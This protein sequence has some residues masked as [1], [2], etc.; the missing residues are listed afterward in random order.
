MH[1]RTLLRSG[2][3]AALAGLAGCGAIL[4]ESEAALDAIEGAADS[5]VAAH[6][7]LGSQYD[8]FGRLDETVEFDDDAVR[9]ELSTAREDLD[10]AEESARLDETGVEIENLRAVADYLEAL[11]DAGAGLATG[12]NAT[13]DA[14]SAYGDGEYDAAVSDLGTAA[15]TIDGVSERISNAETARDRIDAGSLESVSVEDLDDE[16]EYL[17][18]AH[19]GYGVLVDGFDRF[20]R[21]ER[22]WDAANEEYDAENYGTAADSYR[23]GEESLGSAAET[24]G[25]VEDGDVSEET[26]S[27]LASYAD[28]ST[29]GAR[30]M[31]VLASLSETM[32]SFEDAS[33]Y[34]SASRYDDAIT[35]LEAADGQVDSSREALQA[36]SDAVSS[37]DVDDASTPGDADVEQF[38]ERLDVAGTALDALG[39][40][41]P[42][43]VDYV[44]GLRAMERGV[45]AGEEERVVEAAEL[46]ETAAGHFDDAQTDFSNAEDVATDDFRSTAVDLVCNAGAYRD[47]TQLYAE[48]YRAFDAGDQETATARFEEGDRAIA[49]CE[50]GG[51]SATV[52][53]PSAP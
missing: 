44:R 47:G 13:Y 26:G 24:F 12:Y 45:A 29:A 16:I 10:A 46:L 4:G 53:T 51:D 35:S 14:A 22:D 43:F 18:R 50:S 7:E 8:E 37:L 21:A 48:A 9:E 20:V 38:Q 34:L 11:A 52:A 36:A 6:D 31:A 41:I 25:G 28:L 23:A 39:H 30:V 1:R 42:G 19:R 3:V 33:S 15:E 49:R 17:R 5:L 2:G 32:V 40:L 27:M